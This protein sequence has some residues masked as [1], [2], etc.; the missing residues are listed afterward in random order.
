MP[1]GLSTVFGDSALTLTAQAGG[2]VTGGTVAG[3]G[4]AGFVVLLVHCTAATGTGPT[5][6][7]SLEESADGSTGWTA[8]TASAI[9]Q[10]AG[11][12]NRVAFAVPTKSFVRPT[13]TVAGT[14]PAVTARVAL[15]VFSD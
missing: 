10:L 4:A 12:G 15:L 1:A 7:V 6:D 9:T 2:T 11:A 14:T 13:A 3:S 5:L 8:V